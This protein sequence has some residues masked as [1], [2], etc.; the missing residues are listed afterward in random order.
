MVDKPK[1]RDKTEYVDDFIIMEQE[2][3][4]SIITK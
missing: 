3:L 1:F 2:H 4:Y